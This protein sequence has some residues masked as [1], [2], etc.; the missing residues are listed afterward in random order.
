[1]PGLEGIME[2]FIYD[3]LMQLG[4]QGCG[5]EFTETES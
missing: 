4:Q 1:M 2:L 5:W 3:L